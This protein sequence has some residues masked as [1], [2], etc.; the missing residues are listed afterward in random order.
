MEKITI[1]ITYNVKWWLS[2]HVCLTV[3]GKVINTKLG[4]QL[5]PILRGNKKCYFI[6]GAFISEL[7]RY[8]KQVVC[9]F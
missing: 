6:N 8:E 5:K 3:C 1:S 4:K 7:I 2:E 9:P